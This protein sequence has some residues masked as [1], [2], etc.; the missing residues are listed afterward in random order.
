[1]KILYLD[2]FLGMETEMIL[3]ALL[4][5]GIEKD[6]VEKK[7]KEVFLSACVECADVKRAGLEAFRADVVFESDK[8]YGVKEALEYADL[9]F[10]DSMEKAF[11]EN[12]F[13][14][15]FEADKNAKI[16]ESEICRLY[17]L[18]L[19][20]KAVNA[21][22]IISSQI[23]EGSGF[24]EKDGEFFM[25]PSVSASRIFEIKKIPVQSKKIEKELT[26]AFGAAVLSVVANE[27]G[28]MPEMD[29][30]KIGY[31][32]GKDDLLLPNLMRAVLGNT[33]GGDLR[34]MF[35]SEDLFLEIS[36]EIFV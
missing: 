16:Q 13:K 11:F 14:T 4:S 22:Y 25:I 28:A 12:V 31:G 26:G 3:G 34:K 6:A 32:A 10:D 19:A 9:R 24:C 35:E 5:L 2:F 21:D 20:I 15:F 23:R 7:L 8:I 29:I 33:G 1:M 30:E 36:E 17:A 18:Y 27:Y